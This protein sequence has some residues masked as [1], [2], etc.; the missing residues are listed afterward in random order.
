MQSLTL[1]NVH[2]TT[3]PLQTFVFSAWC[4]RASFDTL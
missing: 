3:D 4:E 2:G 1:Y